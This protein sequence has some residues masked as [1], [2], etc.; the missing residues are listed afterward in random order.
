MSLTAGKLV[1]K[2]T[3]M[4]RLSEL[5]ENQDPDKLDSIDEYVNTLADAVQTYIQSAIVTVP[6]TG[7]ISPAGTVGGPVTGISVTGNL[8]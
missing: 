1:F 5:K 6:G 8:S 2:A 3:M 4:A 7:L